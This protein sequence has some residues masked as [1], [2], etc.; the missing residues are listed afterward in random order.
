MPRVAVTRLVQIEKNMVPRTSCRTQS[1]L[2]ACL[3]SVWQRLCTIAGLMCWL[4]WT[5]VHGFN[6][7]TRLTYRTCMA[8]RGCSSMP[9][10]K[11]QTAGRQTRECV[12]AARSAT[13]GR[14]SGVQLVDICGSEIHVS[15]LATTVNAAWVK[16]Q[17]SHWV[18][19]SCWSYA[20][21]PH[22][23]LLST[24]CQADAACKIRSR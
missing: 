3:L 18:N 16:A 22:R 8:V 19:G 20:W 2:G 6:E 11:A 7:L 23:H 15:H 5:G 13:Q 14:V 21:P 24:S 10:T 12:N 17:E 1:S 9:I 4:S